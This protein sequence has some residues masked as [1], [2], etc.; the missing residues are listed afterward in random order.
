[1]DKVR[2]REFKDKLDRMM[3]D[4]VEAQILEVLN[5]LTDAMNEYV[6]GEGAV[7]NMVVVL[8]LGALVG[9]MNKELRDQ[10]EEAGIEE[11]EWATMEPFLLAGMKFGETGIADGDCNRTCDGGGQWQ[12]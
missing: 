8:A 1:M 12:D 5:H 3:P 7:Q 11:Q 4:D 9:T 6:K 10:F 2:G